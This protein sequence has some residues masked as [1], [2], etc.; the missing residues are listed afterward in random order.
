MSDAQTVAFVGLGVM[1]FPMAGHLSRAGHHVQV[2]NRTH[3]R[4]ADWCGRYGGRA[5]ASPKAAASG[6]DVVF[7]CVGNDDDVRSVVLGADGAL[8]GI[9]RGGVLVDHTTA[10]ADL[11]RELAAAAADLGVGF[12]DAPVSGGQAGAENGKLTVMAG[13]DAATFGRV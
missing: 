12:I 8:A 3:E 7:V 10:S 5:C 13:G 11:A 2:Y 1:G 6:A 9:G 4:A